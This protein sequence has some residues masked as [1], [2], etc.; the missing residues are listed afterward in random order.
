MLS[1]TITYKRSNRVVETIGYLIFN[2]CN[3]TVVS[4]VD[5]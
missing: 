4:P 2:G 1:I 3:Y 5:A